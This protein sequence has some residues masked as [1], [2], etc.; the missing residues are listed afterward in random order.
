M[1]AP[2]VVWL[3]LA[4]FNSSDFD[5]GIMKIVKIIE[6]VLTFGLSNY[7][8]NTNYSDGVVMADSDILKGKKLTYTKL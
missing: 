3:F 8:R 5:N 2:I 4:M 6:T 1:N 7:M